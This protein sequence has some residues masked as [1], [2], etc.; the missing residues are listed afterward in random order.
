V[1][2]GS[3]DRLEKRLR[4]FVERKDLATAI[5][6]KNKFESH[7]RAGKKSTGTGRNGEEKLASRTSSERSGACRATPSQRVFWIL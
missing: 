7:D 4:E 3:L 5:D 6:L 1:P 2:D